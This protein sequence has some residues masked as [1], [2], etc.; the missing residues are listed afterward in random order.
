MNLKNSEGVSKEAYCRF[1]QSFNLDCKWKHF[2]KISMRR[3][4]TKK[5]HVLLKWMYCCGGMGWSQEYCTL[6][7][8]IHWSCPLTRNQ[9]YLIRAS[10]HT[11]INCWTT[12]TEVIKSCH[13]LLPLALAD[14]LGN[15]HFKANQYE[16]VQHLGESLLPWHQKGR[17]EVVKVEGG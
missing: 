1:C 6:V 16:L 14:W 4:T 15:F 2:C 13:F 9:F 5:W 10:G 11:F 17:E 12:V 3:I 7:Q 8:L